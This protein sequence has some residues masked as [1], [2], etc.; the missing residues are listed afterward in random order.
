MGS[1]LVVLTLVIFLILLYYAKPL[2]SHR[3][4]TRKV[5]ITFI[6]KDGKKKA[7]ILYLYPDDPLWEIIETHKGQKHVQ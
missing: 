1:Y 6:D 5:K 3:L 7:D 4:R 2:I